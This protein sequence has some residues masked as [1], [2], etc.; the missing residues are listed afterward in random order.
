MKGF[1]LAALACCGNA[2][3]GKGHAS[4]GGH[5]ATDFPDDGS[6]CAAAVLPVFASTRMDGNGAPE[7]PD[8]GHMGNVAPARF[9]L[10]F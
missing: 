3:H 10:G 4:A 6:A 7:L 2:S 8:S 9:A 5:T 1:L